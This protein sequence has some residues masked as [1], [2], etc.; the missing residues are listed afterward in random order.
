[1]PSPQ[2]VP[3]SLSDSAAKRIALIKEQ[4]NRPAAMLRVTVSSGGCSGFQYGFVFDETTTPDDII[5]EKDGV[6]V[7]TDNMSLLY[8]AGS[9][10]DFTEDMMGAAFAIKNPNATSS[11]S[12]GSSFTVG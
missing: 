11:C 12:C 3:L 5:I 4:E 10:I 8:L 7:V 6:R 1:M 2:N 9:Q